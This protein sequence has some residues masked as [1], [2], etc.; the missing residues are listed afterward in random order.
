MRV[1]YLYSGKRRKADLHEALRVAIE[2]ARQTVAVDM[3]VVLTAVDVV[4]NPG[5]VI[6]MDDTPNQ[7]FLWI[8]VGIDH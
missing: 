2:A 8:Q 1:L 6:A 4:Q 7:S 5:Q 3:Q